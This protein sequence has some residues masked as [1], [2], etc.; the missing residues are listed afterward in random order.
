MIAWFQQCMSACLS[1][2]DEFKFGYVI[3]VTECTLNYYI[4]MMMELMDYLFKCV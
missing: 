4:Y 3:C 1:T 2:R